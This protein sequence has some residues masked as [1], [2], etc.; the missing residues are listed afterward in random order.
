MPR[1]PRGRRDRVG[2]GTAP[3]P[4]TARQV[5]VLRDGAAVAVAVTPGISDGRMTEIIGGDLQPGMQVITDQKT[6]RRRQ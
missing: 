6:R 1:L 3:A 4:R 5:W 2:A